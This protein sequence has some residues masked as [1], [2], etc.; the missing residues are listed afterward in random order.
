MQRPEGEDTMKRTAVLAIIGCLLAASA[1][2]GE[3]AG[4]VKKPGRHKAIGAVVGGVAGVILGGYAAYHIADSE[5][6]FF[7]VWTLLAVGGVVGGYAAA[8]GFGADVDQALE[9]GRQSVQQAR[10]ASQGPPPAL[11]L[12]WIPGCEDL[13][14]PGPIA[15]AGAP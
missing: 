4:G 13:E 11:R 9:R 7:T 14:A 6:G 15:A 5:G 3:A 2:A 10:A 1:P 8:G 12:S